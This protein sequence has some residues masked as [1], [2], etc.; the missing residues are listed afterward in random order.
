MATGTNVKL[1]TEDILLYY[2]NKINEA[3]K[4]NYVKKVNSIPTAE[5]S[6]ENRIVQYAG[7]N[8]ADYISGCFYKCIKLDDGTY[9]WES[10]LSVFATK[11]E[12]KDYV[13]DRIRSLGS[14]IHICGSVDSEDLLPVLDNAI[15]DL[16]HCK[17]DG[18][19]Y[20][21]IWND[22][23]GTG[24]FENLGP[25]VDMSDYVLRSEIESI[26]KDID[27][28]EYVKITELDNYATK[29]YVDEKIINIEDVVRTSD[30]E[31][32]VR[33]DDITDV[34]RDSDIADVVRTSDITDVVRTGD[35]ED[36]VRDSDITDVVRNS[37]IEDVVRDFD[38][39]DVVRTS[40]I[41]D[42][43]RID[44]LDPYAFKTDLPLEY[45]AASNTVSGVS[46]F[47]DWV[48]A[49]NE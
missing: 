3:C 42:V 28:E 31:D 35:I 5:A 19:E 7:E 11:E 49:I 43:V 14:L 15:G 29:D 21:Y 8:D 33:V 16:Y 13:D 41:E 30:I 10:V 22:D 27:F 39:T 20:L 6:Q 2:I 12:V 32:V 36:V 40:D 9:K 45:D 17:S 38:I 4:N 26:L 25:L 24:Y 37:D 1:A 34:V 48:D 47:K 46:D 44:D 23:V 18:C